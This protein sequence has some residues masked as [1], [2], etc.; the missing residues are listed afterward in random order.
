[1]RRPAFLHMRKYICK[2][3]DQLRGNHT[4]DHRLCFHYKERLSLL[5]KSEILSCDG[6][7][8]FV[9]HLVIPKERLSPDQVNVLLTPRFQQISLLV[10]KRFSLQ[11]T[12]K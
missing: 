8:W 11:F 12:Q 3:T 7:A 9:S 4:V 1:M 5:P 6:T 10:A 2:G